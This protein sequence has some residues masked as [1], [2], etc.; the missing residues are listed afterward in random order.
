MLRINLPFR[1]PFVTTFLHFLNISHM[2]WFFRVHAIITLV[3]LLFTGCMCC[4]IYDLLYEF[5]NFKMISIH[6]QG[7]Q[8]TDLREVGCIDL[9]CPIFQSEKLARI[10]CTLYDSNFGQII[11]K[12][13]VWNW[14]WYRL[15][16]RWR[17]EVNPQDKWSV[18]LFLDSS[19]EIEQIGFSKPFQN[20]TVDS[21]S[22]TQN[23][24]TRNR[25]TTSNSLIQLPLL[26]QRTLSVII[27]N[28]EKWTQ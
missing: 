1:I 6:S 23:E 9:S 3:L 14:F 7:Q 27:D 15:S 22:Q 2:F 13:P 17:G 25:S 5:V 28:R 24:K 12:A 19:T 26:A 20:S 8:N 10:T 18:E 21:H 4:L 11:C 16:K